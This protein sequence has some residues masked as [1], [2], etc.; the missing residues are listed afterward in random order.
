MQTDVVRDI[1]C[2]TSGGVMIYFD[3][4]CRLRH[5]GHFFVLEVTWAKGPGRWLTL[6]ISGRAGRVRSTSVGVYWV[7]GG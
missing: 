7:W 3:K 2:G 5:Y 1:P 4:V 6:L